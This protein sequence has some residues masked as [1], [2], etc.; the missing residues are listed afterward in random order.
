M[1][2][3]E[4]DSKEPMAGLGYIGAAFAHWL[5]DNPKRSNQ[6]GAQGTSDDDCPSWELVNATSLEPKIAS[7]FFTPTTL[8]G[9]GREENYSNL[10]K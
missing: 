3:Y 6:S 9:G 1:T 5:S 7:L 2:G 8:Q 10:W 4:C